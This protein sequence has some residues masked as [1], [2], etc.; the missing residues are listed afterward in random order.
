[1]QFLFLFYGSSV[2][3]YRMLNILRFIPHKHRLSSISEWQLR[4]NE[5]KVLFI[6]LFVKCIFLSLFLPSCVTL[7]LQVNLQSDVVH[8]PEPLSIQE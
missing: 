7:P 2:R 5:N 3:T 6:Y 1:M 8:L 4:D